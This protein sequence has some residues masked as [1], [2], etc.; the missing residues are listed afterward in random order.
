VRLGESRAYLRIDWSRDRLEGSTVV[1]Q[2]WRDIEHP[3]T[4]GEAGS[5]ERE[6][7]GEGESGG[8][9]SRG[10]DGTHRR[11]MC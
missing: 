10:T 6:R 1:G 5:A 2:W 8:A 4:H 9:R 3:A 11:Y 7:E